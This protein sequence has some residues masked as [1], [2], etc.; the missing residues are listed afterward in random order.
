MMKYTW[1]S[2]DRRN[3]VRHTNKV[4]MAQMDLLR[5]TCRDDRGDS[6]NGGEEM[7]LHY[8]TKRKK[9]KSKQLVKC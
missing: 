3:N 8:K 9:N 2:N 5:Q 4:L 6:G 1:L 7:A